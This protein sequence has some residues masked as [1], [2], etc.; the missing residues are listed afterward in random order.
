MQKRVLHSSIPEDG[1]I[2]DFVPS[3]RLPRLL[4]EWYADCRMRQHSPRTNEL[5]RGLLGRLLWYLADQ[6]FPDCGRSELRHFMAYLDC[7]HLDA[8]GRWGYA[9]ETLA[10]RPATI[11]T[12]H[13]HL[14]AFFA[15]LEEEEYIDD[16]PFRKIKPPIVRADQVQPFS[17]DQ[18]VAFIE[19]ART[20]KYPAR[21]EAIVRFLVDTGL[22]A[23]ELCE[24]KREDCDLSEL[25]ARVLGKGNKVRTV[26]F[27]RRTTRALKAYLRLDEQHPGA[28]VFISERGLAAG[29]KLTRRGLLQLIGRLGRRAGIHRERC[30]PHTFRHTFA[31]E[32]LRNGGNVLSLK[33]LMGHTSLTQTDR[34]VA[35]AN[36]DLQ[37]QH[38][39]FSP[40]DR[41][42]V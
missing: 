33:L 28:P 13:R 9:N 38:R 6:N 21:D 35:L 14:R 40:G 15:W 16:S 12:Y 18:I 41:V 26:C 1:Q 31:V 37:E 7:G 20:S 29:E 36:A 32:Y 25:Q 5:R 34:Y 27:G 8:R 19:A 42:R 39:Q 10:L 4:D 23:T 11:A 3:N 24:L 22:R 2:K 17:P 30:S